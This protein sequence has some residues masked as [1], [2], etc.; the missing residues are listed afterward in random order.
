MR[1]IRCGKQTAATG[2]ATWD[3]WILLITPDGYAFDNTP[4]L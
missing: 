4:K 2:V 1:L 3:G